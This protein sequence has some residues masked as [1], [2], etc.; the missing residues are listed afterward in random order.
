[1]VGDTPAESLHRLEIIHLLDKIAIDRGSPTMSNRV[2]SV[3]SSL[4]SFAVD[5]AL[6][7]VNPV[8]SIRWKEKENKRDRVYSEEEIKALWASFDTQEQPIRS[9]YNK[10]FVWYVWQTKSNDLL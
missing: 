2:K 7:E 3:L 8:T 5:R 6:V 1:M 10:G 9:I 4:Y